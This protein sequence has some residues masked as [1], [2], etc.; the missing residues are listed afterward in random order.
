MISVISNNYDTR[1][2]TGIHCKLKSCILL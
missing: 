1:S 2:G